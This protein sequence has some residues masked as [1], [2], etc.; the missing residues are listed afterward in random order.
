M[1]L[2]QHTHFSIDGRV[3]CIIYIYIYIQLSKITVPVFFGRLVVY[4]HLEC[5][6]QMLLFV[7]RSGQLLML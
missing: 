7:V 4:F 6:F 3:S 5:V 2:L 1:F